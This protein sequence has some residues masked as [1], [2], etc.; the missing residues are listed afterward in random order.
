MRTYY[1]G[2]DVHGASIVMV[3]LNGA[4]KVVME[5]VVETGAERVRG[6]LSWFP[7]CLALQ[8]ASAEHMTASVG[9]NSGIAGR[10]IRNRE[11]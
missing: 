1:V 8:F 7:I 10:Q 6:F 11:R 5:S 2:M 4:G 9:K 3:V